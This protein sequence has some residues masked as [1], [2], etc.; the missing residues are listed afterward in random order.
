VLVERKKSAENLCTI[1]LPIGRYRLRFKS[2]GA[3][4]LPEYTG[5]VWRGA[6]GHALKKVVCVTHHDTCLN[7]LLS[8]S[9]PYSYIFETPPPPDAQKMRKYTA[10]PHP[11]LIDPPTAPENN[12]Y[13]LGLTLFGRGNAYLPYLIHAFKRAGK[14]GLG[15]GRLPMEMID[16]RQAQPADSDEWTV[17]FEPLGVLRAFPPDVPSIPTQPPAVR[18]VFQTHLRLQRDGH[19]VSPQM[20]RFRDFFSTL[21]RRIS[22]LTSFHTDTPLETD[23]AGLTQLIHQVESISGN[24]AWKEWSRYSSRQKTAIRMDGLL[25][26]IE[27]D[28]TGSPELWPYLWLGQWV[29]V[30]KG[31]SMGLGR[32]TIHTASLP[33]QQ[34]GRN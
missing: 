7:C 18:L 30:G 32:Y 15:K 1:E 23:F 6:L 22:M 26:E 29:H 3:A 31:T 20:F 4:R 12:V 13:Q 33:E 10:A 8:R 17:I 14:Q 28:L 2:C 27:V 11:F 19:L 21:L 25:G 34:I 24:L 5:S 9:C 16:V